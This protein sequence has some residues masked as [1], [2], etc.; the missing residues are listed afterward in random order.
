MLC[1]YL[2]PFLIFNVIIFF[3]LMTF[4]HHNQNEE[5]ERPFSHLFLGIFASILVHDRYLNN[6]ARKA[7]K[8]TIVSFLTAIGLFIWSALARCF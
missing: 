2:E 4:M 1:I 5:I 6:R 7:R 8:P 3:S